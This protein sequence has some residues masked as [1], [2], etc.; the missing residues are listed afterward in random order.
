MR[1]TVSQPLQHRRGSQIVWLAGVDGCRGGWFAVLQG[2]G[3]A[4]SRVVEVRFA[5]CRGFSEVMNLPENPAPI[6][7]DIPIGLLEQAEPGGR[8]CDRAARALL[9]RGRASSIFTPP[10]RAALQGQSYREAMRLNGAGMS[11]QTFNLMGKIREVDALIEPALQQRIFEA[12]PELAFLTLAG[13]PLRHNKKT[14]AGGRERE[15]L[16]G[17]LFGAAFIKP[18]EVR[19]CFP[20]SQVGADDVL[21]AYALALTARRI[22][23]GSAVRLPEPEPERDFRGLRMEIWY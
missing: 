8:S 14:P 22:H 11:K 6:A 9:G 18:S 13:R 16:L 5:L 17:P 3:Q 1:A 4:S 7:V 23:A 20:R 10:T 21:D 12:H 2:R 15:A 19:D